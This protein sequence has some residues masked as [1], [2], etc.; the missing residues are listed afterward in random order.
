AGEAV[1]T[2]ELGPDSVNVFNNQFVQPLL[3]R[4]LARDFFKF[5]KVNMERPCPYKSGDAQ[6][7]SKECGIGYCDDE[8]PEALRRPLTFKDRFGTKWSWEGPERLKNVY[9]V[10][11]LE[12]RALV[13]AAPYLE[14][15][16]FYT[17][18]EG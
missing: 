8:V 2:C 5:Y 14:K 10:Y 16:R 15:E 1:G 13:K 4:I 9:F 18:N 11:L 17:G 3:Q 7:G 12:L 6:C